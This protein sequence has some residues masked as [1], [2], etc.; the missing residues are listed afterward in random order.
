MSA[1]SARAVDMSTIA[2][3]MSGRRRSALDMIADCFR[4]QHPEAF[5]RPPVP[6]PVLPVE[7]RYGRDDMR[8]SAPAQAVME[9]PMGNPRAASLDEAVPAV[10]PYFEA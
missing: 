2:V 7:V 10:A 5:G 3:E 4:H 8:Q 1:M 6:S 9:E